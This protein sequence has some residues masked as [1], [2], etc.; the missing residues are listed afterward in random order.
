[1]ATPDLDLDD[2]TTPEAHTPDEDAWLLIKILA[3]NM[4]LA[5]STGG[6]VL[7]RYDTTRLWQHGEARYRRARRVPSGRQTQ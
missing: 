1:M 4:W 7:P 6:V 2:S 3:H 5:Q